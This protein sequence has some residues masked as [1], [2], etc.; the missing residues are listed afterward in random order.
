MR[1][2]REKMFE[3][4][5]DDRVVIIIR[6]EYTTIN[7]GNDTVDIEPEEIK[8]EVWDVAREDENGVIHGVEKR[9]M[10]FDKALKEEYLCPKHIIKYKKEGH[11]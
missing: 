11:N 5:K 9:I 7:A 10:S 3:A 4:L 1:K 6:P 8:L 2:M